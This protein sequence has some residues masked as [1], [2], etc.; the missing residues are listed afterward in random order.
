ML[1]YSRKPNRGASLPWP[2]TV[3][4]QQITHDHNLY[5]FTCCGLEEP[6]E[7]TVECIESLIDGEG[8][9]TVLTLNFFR[10]LV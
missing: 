1:S 9:A 10:N 2:A 6:D 8:F 3:S 7:D 4:Y 5:L